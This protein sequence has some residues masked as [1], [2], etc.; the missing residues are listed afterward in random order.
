MWFSQ[1]CLRGTANVL[2]IQNNKSISWYAFNFLKS[3]SDHKG[4]E[5]NSWAARSL[6]ARFATGAAGPLRHSQ[7]G[8]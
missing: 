3:K 1:S 5:L 4:V 8:A 2:D 6:V 7:A